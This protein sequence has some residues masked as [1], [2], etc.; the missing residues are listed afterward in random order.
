MNVKMCHS[1]YLKSSIAQCYVCS[2]DVHDLFDSDITVNR[3]VLGA[4]LN[5]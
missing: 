3:N 5:K 1:S 4:A 2:A